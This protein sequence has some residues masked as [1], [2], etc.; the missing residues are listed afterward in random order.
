MDREELSTYDG[1]EGRKAYI[2]YKGKVYDVT[3]SRLWKSGQHVKRHFAGR[4]LTDDLEKAPHSEEVFAHFIM[5]DSLSDP[6]GILNVSTVETRNDVLRE[7]YRK[8]HPHPIFIHFPMGLLSF[9]V[10]MQIMFL[11]SKVPSFET[12]AFHC[13][14]AGGLF[15]LPTTASGFF[16][17]WINYQ[18][19][20]SKIFIT[21]ICF[22]L[23][24][25]LMCA[26]EIWLRFSY[27][28]ISYAETSLSNFYNSLVVLNLPIMGVIGFNGGK[29][30]WG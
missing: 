19:A 11:Y 14:T 25:T 23:L 27:T 6:V 12:T 9:A 10:F 5:V 13:I 20:P 18:R 30:T 17:W 4:D 16:S 21:K 29:I 7:I 24:L 2:G 3:E 8:L 15:L 22:S 26:T 28:N 1:K